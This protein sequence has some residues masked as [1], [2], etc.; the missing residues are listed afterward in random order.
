MSE[1]AG[2]FEAHADLSNVAV[3]SYMASGMTDFRV[4]LLNA[5]SREQFLGTGRT[6]YGRPGR[7]PSSIHLAFRDMYDAD[8]LKF[9]PSATLAGVV[10]EAGIKFDRKQLIYCGGG[11]AASGVFFVLLSLARRISRFTTAQ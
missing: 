11:I 9:Y 5:L 3:M 2:S 7:I 6:H 4:Q 10:A 1:T 8:T